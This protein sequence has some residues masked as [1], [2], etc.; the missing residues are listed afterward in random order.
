VPS[1]TGPGRGIQTAALVQEGKAGG[2][3]TAGQASTTNELLLRIERQLKV[4]N[5]SQTAPEAKRQYKVGQAMMDGA[6]IPHGI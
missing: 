6:G 3:P 1:P 4:L 5:G 2:G